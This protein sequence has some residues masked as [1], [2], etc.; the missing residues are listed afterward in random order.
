[1]E[2][3]KRRK[4]FRDIVRGYSTAIIQDKEVFIKHLTPH[5]QVELEE[6]EERYFLSAQKR[7]VPTEKDMLDYLEDEGQ[8]TKEDERDITEKK[9]Y[10]KN[11]EKTLSQL[12]LGKEIEKQ[13][14]VIEKERKE[15]NEKLNQKTALIG[16]T[17]EKYAK[18]RM[19]DFYVINSFFK[20]KNFNHKL[21][22]ESDFDELEDFDIKLLVNTYNSI[23]EFFSEENVQYTVLEEFYNPYLSFAEDSMQFYGKPFCELT[24]NQV[25]LIVYTRIF[26]NIFDT[27]ENIPESI[28]KDP[29]KLL[30]FG[31]SSKDEK[32][33][34]KKQISEGDGSTI[35][36]AK[37]EDYERLG[38]DQGVKSVS[39]HEEAKKKG[40]TLDME[41]L[42]K[43]HGVT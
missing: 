22:E 16:N 23:F 5:D 38:V 4:V 12:V 10:L 24:Y 31:S 32:E 30:E 17:C 21:Y 28:L 2:T 41:D 11:L 25:R 9:S 37:Q 33:K 15:L 20:V 29:V 39:L 19:N 6:I 26:K 35:V 42:M 40:G 1:M 3:V 43:L 8:W 18:E 27:N 13:K 34:R 7:G 14:K 36:G